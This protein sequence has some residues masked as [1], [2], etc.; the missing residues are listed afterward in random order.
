[1][2]SP[3]FSVCIPNFNYARYL[4]QTIRSVL[5]QTFQDFEII[6]SD[7]ASTDNSVEV[8]RS[9]QD[10]RIRL[11]QNSCNI[12]YAPNLDKATESSTGQYLILLSSDDIMK[13]GALAEYAAIIR[14][15]ERPRMDLVISSA[16][17]LINETG[18]VFDVK[19]GLSAELRAAMEKRGIIRDS[20]SNAELEIYRGLDLFRAAMEGTMTNVGQFLST[21]YSKGLFEKVCGYHSIMSVIP[22]AH[23]SHKLMQQNPCVIFLRKSLFQYRV[24]GGGNYHQISKDMRVYCDR[25]LMTQL[26]TQ[27][28][29]SHVGMNQR[30]LRQNFIRRFC[31][32]NPAFGLLTGRG[33]FALRACCFGWA[34]YPALMRRHWLVWCIPFLTLGYPALSVCYRLY[35]MLKRRR[36]PSN[37]PK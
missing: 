17:D 15:L 32:E 21:C 35:G 34:V 2:T 19:E 24:H 33:G 28:E 10:R 26:Y 13:Q 16:I 7:N 11:V 8:V 30:D 25:Y 9:F 22:D 37:K 14:S 3:F 29:L 4:G 23:F 6:V 12:G 1:M 31:L 5:D 27:K 36:S 18:K 20:R